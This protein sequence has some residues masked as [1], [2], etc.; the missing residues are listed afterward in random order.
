MM[1]ARPC[2]HQQRRFYLKPHTSDTVT[3]CLGED[4]TEGQRQS[5]ESSLTKVTIG[6]YHLPTRFAVRGQMGNR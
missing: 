5:G 6:S 4:L 3:T 1:A 2:C